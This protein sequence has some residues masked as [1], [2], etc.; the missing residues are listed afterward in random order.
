MNPSSLRKRI[1]WAIGASAAT[2]GNV[3]CGSSDSD[4]SA[5]TTDASADRDAGGASSGGMSGTGG[6]G[7]GGTG[8]VA[9]GGGMSG[10][11]GSSGARGG[12]GGQPGDAARGNGGAAGGGGVDTAG[13]SP[14]TGGLPSVRRP[15]LVGSS[16][17]S[18][19]VS[20]RDD[21]LDR[22]QNQTARIEPETRRALAA[23]WL[24][25][26]REEHASV[27]AFA[28]FTLLMMSVGAPPDLVAASQRASLDEIAHARACFGL[29]A[30][31]GASDRGPDALA[32][33]DALAPLSIAEIAALTTEEGCVGE[34]LGV[35][36]A[37]EQLAFASDPEVV[38]VLT[39]IVAD[40]G[41]HAELAWR[42][43]AWAI[44]KGG[45]EVRAAVER[46]AASAMAEVRRMPERDYGVDVVAWHAHGRTTCAEARR[47]AERGLRQ[48]VEP[49]LAA[50]LGSR[51]EADGEI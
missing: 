43:V 26:G 1:L 14:G 11:G 24:A 29:A 49:A 13:G 22:F 17:R 33:H 25:D 42:F 27:A 32:V 3:Q 23:A 21:W 35:V 10:G 6:S 7:A 15:F 41:R 44:R 12:D 51:E 37:G 4:G 36:L 30:R 19:G 16:L 8:A 40:E 46:A 34:T 28:R 2:A 31:Y 39:K 47:A 50:V 48:V 18:A 20:R 9:A 5:S 38:T 45:N